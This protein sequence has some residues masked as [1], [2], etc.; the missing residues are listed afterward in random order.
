MR[1][2]LCLFAA[3]LL[4]ATLSG[5]VTEVTLDETPPTSTLAVGES[6]TV[7]LRFLRFDVEQF[8]QS[9][10]LTDLKALPTRVLQDT[11][12][13]DLDMSTL[14]QN[15][16]QQVAYLP[17]AE[18]HALAQPAR[19][20]WKLLNLTAE[21]TDL[22]GT[23]LEPLLG[24]GKAVGLPPSLILADLAQVG[25]NDPLISTETTAQAVLSNVVA[26]HPN[27]QFRRGPVNVDHPDGLYLVTPGSIPV[28][29]ADVVDSFAS[30]AERFGPAPAWEEG[31]PAHPGFVVASSPVSAATDAFRMKVK[32]NLNAL[33]YKGVD[34]T[35]A[36]VASVNSTGGQIENIFDFDRPDWLSLEGLAEDLKIGELTMAIGEN[37]GFLPSG[38]ARDPLPY[39]NSPVWETP[40]WEME[41]LLASAGFARAQA[42]TEHCSVY[43]P[44]GTVEEPFE[45]VNVCVDGTGWVDIQVDPSVVLDEPPPPP[46]YFW[47]VLLEVAQ[48]RLH[49]GELAEGAADVEI[50]VRDVPVGVSTETLVT[51]I[52]DN[53]QGNPSALRGVAEQLNDNTAGDADFYYYQTAEGE[54]F[55]YFIAPEDLRLDAEGNPVREYGYQHPG[56]YADAD[57]AEKI[58][59]REEVDG[60]RAHEKVAIPVGTSLFFEDDGG[61]VYRVDAGEKPSLH[62]AALT[63]TRIR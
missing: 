5:C 31:A 54:D 53:I 22:R 32:V 8:Q 30:L 41:H 43:A 40:R 37:D 13:L 39:G 46:S 63:L 44:Q 33:P 42:L 49:D 4:A 21:S 19:N 7:E 14:V 38:D 2:A 15:A 47:D 29:L 48:V 20:L 23:R 35:N 27:A 11:W 62:K 1:R 16:L 55:L 56:F 59:S 10:T 61:A 25:E 51:S 9:L 12:L 18:A 6:R 36:T 28:Y 34:A 3:P 26:T 57:L 17:P 45:A 50:T 52:R 60:D 58:S 24:V